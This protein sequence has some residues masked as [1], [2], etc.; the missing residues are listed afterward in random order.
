MKRLSIS[1]LNHLSSQNKLRKMDPQLNLFFALSHVQRI[2][3]EIEQKKGPIAG[4]FCELKWFRCD[5]D[6]Y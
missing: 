6:Y 4:P 3:H 2:V 1:H 5:I